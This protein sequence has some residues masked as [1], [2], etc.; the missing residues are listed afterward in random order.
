[1]ETIEIPDKADKS[2]PDEHKKVI[3]TETKEV[4]SKNFDGTLNDI[5]SELERAV[6]DLTV[7]QSRIDFLNATKA[8]IE[9][10]LAK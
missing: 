9:A 8:K 5:T 6:N 10:E 3:I 1:M 7:A 2:I 4:V